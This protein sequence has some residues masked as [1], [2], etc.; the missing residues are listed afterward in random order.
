[1]K[2]WRYLAACLFLFA[3]VA[4]AQY[5]VDLSWT[6]PVD[7]TDPVAGYDVF[8]SPHGANT[9][10]L[11]NSTVDTAV[12]YVDTNVTNGQSYDYEIT[13]VDAS[14]VQS[15][16][17]SPVTVSIPNAAPAPLTVAQSGSSAVLSWG[18]PSDSP[19]SVN[20]Y[21]AP[22][23]GAYQRI[24]TGV[25]PNGPY[26]DATATAGLWFYF[27]TFTSSSGVESQWSNI[28][29]VDLTP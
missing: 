15:V 9:Y 2:L 8:R 10:A 18:A 20:V 22:L 7:S 12:T 17:T 5:N 27:I 23:W 13:S 6:A 29:T 14:G 19:A 24:A 25:T 26:T 4:Q 16:P 21:R 11:L 3:A 28:T 1:M